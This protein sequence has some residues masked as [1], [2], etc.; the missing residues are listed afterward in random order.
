MNPAIFLDR[1]GVLVENN[2]N[3]IRSWSEVIIFSEALESLASI[4]NS[5]F[6]VVIV[7]NQS[8]VGRGLVSKKIAVEINNLLVEEIQARG[9]NVDGIFMCSHKPEDNCVCRKPKPGLLF[10]AAK[11]LNLDLKR[12]IMIGDAVTD[13]IAGQQAGIP[14][15]ILLLTGRG[16]A[17]VALLEPNFLK[18]ILVYKTLAEALADRVGCQG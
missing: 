6:K 7:T 14:T 11:E 15:N 18:S 12:S 2:P 5:S 10:Q 3:Y 17:Q 1:D 8:A 13:L 16:K 4:N 9:G